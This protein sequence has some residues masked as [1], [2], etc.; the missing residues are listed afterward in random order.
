MS[1]QPNGGSSTPITLYRDSILT[2]PDLTLMFQ[3]NWAS[4]LCVGLMPHFSVNIST[5]W[6]RKKWKATRNKILKLNIWKEETSDVF[7]GDVA[8]KM[9]P[10]RL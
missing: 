5:F 3:L 6:G 8:E 4:Q 2:K 7:V 9:R 10:K 1:K